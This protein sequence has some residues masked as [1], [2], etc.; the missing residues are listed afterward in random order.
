[1]LHPLLALDFLALAVELLTAFIGACAGYFTLLGEV[2]PADEAAE[3]AM[4]MMGNS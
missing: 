4:Y 2:S 1:M 3:L